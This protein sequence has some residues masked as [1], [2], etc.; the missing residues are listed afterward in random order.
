MSPLPAD[1][2]QIRLVSTPSG[3]LTD[4]HFAASRGPIPELR[5]GEVL[6]KNLLLS[7]DA[8][9]RAWMFGATYRAAVSPG[10]VMHGGTVS[11]VVDSRAPGFSAGDVVSGMGGWQ[12]YAAVDPATLQKCT[13]HR[14]LT[15]QLS[16]YGVAGLTAYHGL[17]HVAGVS[18]GETVVVSAA[19]GS[20]GSL[21]GQIAKQK[22]ARAIGIAGGADKCDWVVRELGFDACIDYKSA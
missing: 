19:A 12:E 11:V 7:I 10:D 1:Q 9:N 5:D 13:A 16:V 15:H 8:A 17:V 22:G 20:V 6:V 3:A 2:L 4:A 18:A 14:P 21:V